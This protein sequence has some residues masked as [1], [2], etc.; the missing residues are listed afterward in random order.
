MDRSPTEARTEKG[1]RR[2]TARAR[3]RGRLQRSLRESNNG[4]QVRRAGEDMVVRVVHARVVD[5]ATH[6]PR[7]PP[8]IHIA[9]GGEADIFPLHVLVHPWINPTEQQQ[10]GRLASF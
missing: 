10:I 7:H 5:S 2:A 6:Q 4:T 1:E 9:V 3:G 8:S